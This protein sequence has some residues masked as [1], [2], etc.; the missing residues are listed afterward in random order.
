[1]LL[2]CVFPVATLDG[3]VEESDEPID[4]SL[5]GPAENA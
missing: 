1:M 2:Y 4:L 5:A 3:N